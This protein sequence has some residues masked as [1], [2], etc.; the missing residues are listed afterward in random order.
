MS[1][2]SLC[3]NDE[4]TDKLFLRALKGEVLSRPP[5]WL[6]RQAGRYLPEYREIRKNAKDFL[7]FCYTPD[8]AVEVTLQPLRRYHMDAAILFSDIL[9]IPDA[10]GQKVN[11]IEG[12]GPA[13]EPIRS[14]E[15]LN[16][17]DINRV[18]DHLA[19][20]FETVNR[21]SREIPKETTLIGF[22]GSPWTVAVYMVEGCGGTDCGNAK[23]WAYKSPDDFQKLIDL[24]VEATAGYLIEQIKNGAEAI[25]LFDSWSGVLGE[26][27]FHRWVIKPTA[28]IVRRIKSV[29]PKT[30][31]IGF[32]RH[33]G[34]LYK[35]FV[36]ETGVDGV[37][38]DD[39]IP[40]QWA[41]KELQS[42]CA[43]QGNLD[44]HLLVMGGVEMET[45]I[46]R[47][48]ETFSKGPFIFNL[49]HG[50]LQFTPPENVARLAEL[51]HGWK[52][53]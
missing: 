52:S 10:L 36:D 48:I 33:A 42:R 53:R 30:P 34:V 6:M 11:F 31:I 15:G 12:Q 20:V 3:R 1:P 7:H 19:P 49:G 14:V 23:T 51:I 32:P 38:L 44:N 2:V 45:E 5:F 26:I 43:V 18:N 37:S 8:L 24:L 28:E 39:T 17:L 46:K 47:I 50:I 4:K 35:D 25:Q 9:V 22:A 21:L 16:R 27:Q 29:Y 41:K 13:L 40:L